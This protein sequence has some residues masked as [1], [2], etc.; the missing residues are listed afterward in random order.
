VTAHVQGEDPQ[1]AGERGED[2]G[3]GAAVE[4]VGVGED[5]VHGPVRRTEVDER[6]RAAPRRQRHLPQP[7]L[8]IDGPV[9]GSS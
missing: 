7:R 1:G 3:V 9:H 6:H 5:D 8:D 4:A 2:A